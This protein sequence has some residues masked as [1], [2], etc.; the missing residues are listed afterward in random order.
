M[1]FSDEFLRNIYMRLPNP[2][3]VTDLI[4]CG[5]YNSSQVAY[6]A[7]RRGDCPPYYRIGKRIIYPKDGVIKWMRERGYGIQN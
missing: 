1:N 6:D 7:R 2:C 5:I 4:K 3:S